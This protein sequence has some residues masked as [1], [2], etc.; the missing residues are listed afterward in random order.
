[1]I[2]I[3]SAVQDAIASVVANFGSR[4][5]DVGKERIK[6][7]VE[8]IGD[9]LSEKER[10]DVPD[11]DAIVES[12]VS[13][14][15][16]KTGQTQYNTEVLSR[17][18]EI[19]E[20]DIANLTPDSLDASVLIQH[21]ILEEKF[22]EWLTDWGYEVKLGEILRPQDAPDMECVADVY[23]EL[24]TMHGA[25][26]VAVNF[27]CDNPPD[28]NRVLALTSKIGAYADA[29]SSFSTND[30]YLIVTP[31]DFTKTS[32]AAMRFQNRKRN[33]CVLGVDGAI[34][35][36][37]ETAESQDGRLSELQEKVSAANMQSDRDR[38]N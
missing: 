35:Y 9:T 1:M 10:E 2:D 14:K 22:K 29:R 31:W 19:P 24:Q 32:I 12:I 5:V 23:G 28:E 17:W 3:N 21:I 4:A 15:A 34:L 36:D 33:Y 38:N 13:R 25:F 20:P 8:N 30:V 7:W 26:E 37:L 27:V 6:N 18:L 16:Q 11:V